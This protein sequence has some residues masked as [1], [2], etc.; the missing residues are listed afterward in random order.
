[1]LID[2]FLSPCTNLKSKWIKELHLI[3]VTETYRGESG[4]KPRRYGHRGKNPE[5]K[6]NGLCSKLENP[7]MGPDKIEKLV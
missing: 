2:L 4:G 3:R 6:S 5:L 1:M 7:Q